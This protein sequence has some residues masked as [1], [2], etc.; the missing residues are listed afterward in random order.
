[1]VK[2]VTGQVLLVNLTLGASQVEQ[3]SED[4][5]RNYLSGLGLGVHLL[6]DRIPP[7]AD[8]L[9][10]ENI[11]GFLAGVLTGMGAMFAGRFLV[12]GKSPLTGGWG[13][14]NCG[15]NLAPAIKQSGFDGIFFEG[16]S[17]QPV[18]VYV[19]DEKV[20]ILPAGD[21]WGKD[22]VET[23]DLL[24][25]KHGPRAR[26]ACIGPAGENLVRFAG[27]SN[28]HGRLAARSGLG[29]V[30]GSKKLKAIVLEGKRKVEVVDPAVI[31]NQSKAI[32]ALMPRGKSSLPGW[33]LGFIGWIMS[34]VTIGFRKDGLMSLPPFSDWGTS[35]GNEVCIIS[36][37]A[38]VRN[39]RGNPS[40]YPS[41]AVGV[42]KITPTQRKK[43]HCVSCPLGCGSIC[44]MSGRY[45]ATHRPEYET[46][47]AFGPN[48]LNR[49]LPNIYDVNE[50]C[51]RM[52]LD[53]IS[54]GAVVSFGIECFENQLID[55]EMTGGLVLKWGDPVTAVKLVEMIVHRQ[56]IGDLLAEGVRIASE[57]LGEASQKFAFHA[58]GQEIP[59]HDPR[60]DPAYGVL[61]ISDPT[62]GRHTVTS[63]TLY[64]MANLWK[65]VSWAPMPPQTYPKKRW[66][67]NSEENARINAAGAMYKAI[68]DCAG[69]CLFGAQMGADRLGIFEMLNA[70]LGF[71]LTADDYMEIGRRVQTLRQSFNLRHGL[72]PAGVKINPLLFGEPP[73]VKGPARGIHYD[74]YGM[75]RRFWSAMGWDEETGVPQEAIA[76]R[77]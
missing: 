26:V 68:L 9:G 28:D 24:M 33:S 50:Y 51:N 38:P 39:W 2:G 23:E 27:I 35:S 5:Y 18:Y 75:Q 49:D 11:L 65:K 40:M 36:G 7:E 1:M 57:R 10:P 56:Q 12:V 53:S 73:A 48:I 46:I 19:H 61:Y 67:E 8:P 25:K 37:D 30:M 55:K 60:I 52:G 63:S 74:L 76:E 54:A 13:D 17:D 22:T 47:A 70:A 59:M 15:G 14:A 20:D 64:E 72:K 34:R 43:Y 31:K 66:Y 41:R 45:Q 6:Y 16:C 44:E 21:L 58:G 32:S 62:P 4:I 69:I 71:N 77:L 42:G 3:V 29:A